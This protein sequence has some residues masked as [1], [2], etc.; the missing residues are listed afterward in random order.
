MSRKGRSGILVGIAVVLLA[1]GVLVWPTPKPAMAH[2]SELNVEQIV[3]WVGTEAFDIMATVTLSDAAGNP[4][5]GFEGV[6][7]SNNSTYI[8]WTIQLLNI[9][10]GA[11]RYKIDWD[12]GQYDWIEEPRPITGLIDWLSA[13]ISVVTNAIPD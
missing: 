11:A 9:P 2:Y 1:V 6:Q 3:D 10:D 4:I 7:L 8:E 5:E 13:D 12:P